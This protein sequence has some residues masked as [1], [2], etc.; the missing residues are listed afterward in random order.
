[1]IENE[2]DKVY[3]IKKK[4]DDATLDALCMI[5]SHLEN[6]FPEDQRWLAQQRIVNSLFRQ[7]YDPILRYVETAKPGGRGVIVNEYEVPL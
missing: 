3:E 1:M 4:I 7:T 5:H 2:I 6:N